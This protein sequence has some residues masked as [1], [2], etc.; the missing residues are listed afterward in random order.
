MSLV[1]LLRL[2]DVYPM[3]YTVKSPDFGFESRRFGPTES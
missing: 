1:A 3:G 2:Y